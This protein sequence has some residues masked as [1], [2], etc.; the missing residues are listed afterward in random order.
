MP[1]CSISLLALC[2][3]LALPGSAAKIAVD[4][5][6]PGP[7]I[8][9]A[10]WGLFLEDINFGADGG[11]YAEL[12]KNRGFEF[13]Q[14]L[15]GWDLLRGWA[16]Q[17]DV[18]VRDDQPFNVK[19]PHYL[20]IRSVA[21]MPI[22]VMTSGYRGIGVRKSDKY[23]FSARL[24]KVQG[25]PTLRVQIYGSGGDLL[26]SQSFTD[27]PDDWSKVV[28]SLEAKDTDA[29]SVLHLTILG[30][31]TVDLDFVSLFPEATWKN[32]N[33][34]LRAD[35][36]QA[37]ADLHP[38]FIRFPGG[39]IVEGNVLATRY[40]WKNT[41]GPV[42]ERQLLVSRWNDSSF[43]RATP[44]YYQSFGLGFFEYFQ[45]CEDLGA[46]P[47]PILNSGM[48][49]QLKSGELCAPEDLQTYIQDALDLIE[50]ANG[51]ATSTWGAKRAAMGHPDPFGMKMI[52]IGNEQWGTAYTERYAQF[53]KA[54]K[55]RH[56]DVQIVATAGGVINSKNFNSTWKSLR[57]LGADIV[58]EHNFA[59]PQ[60]FF[61]NAR[62]YDAQDRNGPKIFMGEYA[63]QSVN[64]MSVKN[65]S[66]FL[67]ALSEAAF[68]TGLERNAD[69]VRMASY[70]PL[71]AHVDAWQWT[72][73]LIW[74][75]NLRTLLTPSYYVQQ[76]YMHNR[77]DRILRSTQTELSEAVQKSL[78][79]STAWDAKT[80]EVILKLV[81]AATQPAKSSIT[82]S[83]VH[84][85]K[86]GTRTV[87]QSDNLEAVNTFEDSNRVIP[88]QSTF[89]VRSPTFEIELP[90]SS[91]TVLRIGTGN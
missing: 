48:A 87:L 85:V 29:K 26:A 60:W 47:L 27:L 8:N 90:A 3:V 15:Q 41:I 78:Y 38:G 51:P 88:Q 20:R 91:F 31:G 79:V 44:D 54:L 33:G 68:L 42:E 5:G 1:R 17:G 56:P 6:H 7:E 14:S 23:A 11:L 43:N 52:G 16:A 80:G 50:F 61:N 73:D 45:L 75:D 65:R 9:P 55:A 77:G 2:S 13:P 89:D 46:Q 4:V 39:C 81:N 84:S 63:A 57:E 24:R 37:L 35:L 64:V 69:V 76:L 10:M 12:I 86:P 66:T 40:Q 25:S 83:G 82:L 22:G 28:A 19:N 36:V 32:R 34:G 67:C 18:T 58:D 21:K 59:Q 30:E 53:A 72:P 71:L 62:R 49:C 74:M 70:A